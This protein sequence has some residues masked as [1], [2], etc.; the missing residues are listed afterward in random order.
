MIVH[1][2]RAQ[3]LRKQA[4]LGLCK[5]KDKAFTAHNIENKT[6]RALWLIHVSKVAATIAQQ[7]LDKQRKS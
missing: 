1:P 4:Y 7:I 5:F 3:E 6:E 2:R